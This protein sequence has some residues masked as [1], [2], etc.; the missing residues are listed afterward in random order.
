MTLFAWA[1]LR[2]IEFVVVAGL[3]GGCR[4]CRLWVSWG[5]P[6]AVGTEPCWRLL[7]KSQV[8]GPHF[9]PQPALGSDLA[10]LGPFW[11][12]H[13]EAARELSAVAWGSQSW[14]GGSLP[15]WS[16]VSWLCPSSLPGHLW[17]ATC[18]LTHAATLL[19][20]TSLL[21][22][23]GCYIW[24]SACSLLLPPPSDQCSKD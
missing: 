14:A 3:N 9:C 2:T 13:Q 12:L 24:V 10:L 8:A 23:A 16:P 19:L 15:S 7:V 21:T 6:G 11:V 5:Q 18:L 1:L 4:G 22:P 17:L 20:V